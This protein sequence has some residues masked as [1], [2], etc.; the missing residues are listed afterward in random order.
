MCKQMPRL[1]QSLFIICQTAHSS[2]WKTFQHIWV[3]T[4]RQQQAIQGSQIRKGEFNITW[5]YHQASWSRILPA[6][7]FGMK[8]ILNSHPTG[9]F[10]SKLHCR[11][12]AAWS[13]ILNKANCIVYQPSLAWYSKVMWNSPTVKAIEKK[14]TV[15]QIW[16]RNLSYLF[17]LRLA[18]LSSATCWF[19]ISFSW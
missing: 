4:N 8:A 12:Q 6:M 1:Q 5:L 10:N 7:H 11:Q 15:M 18:V 14:K 9:V 2:G 17:F 16:K 19:S 13:K 3:N